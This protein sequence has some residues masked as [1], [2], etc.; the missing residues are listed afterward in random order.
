M[1]NGNGYADSPERWM[2][3]TLQ[4]MDARPARPRRPRIPTPEEHRRRTRR[5]WVVCG[6]VALA[7]L[8]G[9]GGTVVLFVA[10]DRDVQRIVAATTIIFQVVIAMFATGFTTPLFLE[11]RANLALSID[12]G[13]ESL[14]LGREAA[15]SMVEMKDEL[16]PVLRELKHVVERMRPAAEASDRL[17]KGGFLGRVEEAV[18]KNEGLARDAGPMIESLRRIEGQVERAIAA[19]LLE[20]M[21]AAAEGL[22]DLSAPQG[23]SPEDID[24]ALASITG[25]RRR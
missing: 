16:L 25:R 3:G 6:L 2:S 23:T 8:V 14:D 24:A 5:I 22:R 21:R 9:M 12:M 15:G 10:Q 13:R 17:V 19:G 4:A 20:N 7:I 18:A 11:Q 1:E